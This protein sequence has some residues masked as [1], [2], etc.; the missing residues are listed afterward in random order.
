MAPLKILDS[1]VQAET[2]EVCGNGTTAP[3][4]PDCLAPNSDAAPICAAMANNTIYGGAYD[5]V[6]AARRGTRACSAH[7]HTSAR[8]PLVA[9]RCLLQISSFQESNL[10]AIN[11]T[12]YPA[13]GWGLFADCMSAACIVGGPGGA[14]TAWDGSP[15]TCFCP[16]ENG[17]A[18]Q[19]QV[20]GVAGPCR[21]AGGGGCSG[22]GSRPMAACSLSVLHPRIAAAQVGAPYTV[23]EDQL[24]EQ[25]PIYM[26][27]GKPL[28][29]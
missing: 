14:A 16:I 1:E 6:S 9:P 3:V 2:V 5:M 24:C 21:G 27:S 10:G 19:Y 28:T 29:T 8:Q 15:I 22:A 23:P 26:L 20:G 4:S 25:H 13:S 11:T 7:L 17:T 18:G 12:C